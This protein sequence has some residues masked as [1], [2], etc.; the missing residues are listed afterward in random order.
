MTT[1]EKIK[2]LRK[3]KMMTQATLVG[4]EITRNMLSRIE[5]GQANPSLETLIYLSKRFDVPVG[6]LLANEKEDAAY[7]KGFL[8]E[9]IRLAYSSKNYKIAKDL[10]LEYGEENNEISLIAAESAFEVAVE[11]FEVGRL[12]SACAA[13]DEAI[14]LSEKTVYH[15]EHIVSAAALYFEYMRGLTPNLYSNIIDENTVEP[16]CAMNMDFCRYAYALVGVD[17][18][19]TTFAKSF[20]E[21]SDA[22]SPIALHLSARMDI[23]NGNW[24]SARS[25]LSRVLVNKTKVSRPVLYSVLSDI[26]IA[27]REINDFKSAYEYST[28]KVWLLEKMLSEE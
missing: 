7:E 8:S 5:N 14:T 24:R 23:K 19:H 25:K 12:H 21:A 26:E 20:V 16:Y 10:A 9:Q 1:G 11:E 2:T 4:G 17:N 6:Y 27:S 13:F 28:E 3:K 22:D 18:G 15:T